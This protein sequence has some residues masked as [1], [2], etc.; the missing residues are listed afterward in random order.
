[1][2]SSSWRPTD[3]NPSQMYI[4]FWAEQ[5]SRSNQAKPPTWNLWSPPPLS[6]QYVY[7]DFNNNIFVVL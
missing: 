3:E 4:F 6:V 7:E 1:M 5:A 2:K